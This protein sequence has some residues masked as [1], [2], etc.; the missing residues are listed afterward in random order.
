MGY[1]STFSLATNGGPE[2]IIEQFRKECDRAM[3]ALDNDGYPAD[4]AKWYSSNEDVIAFSAKHPDVLF[5]LESKGEEGEEACIYAKG[6]QHY[7]ESSPAWT[8]PPFDA[9]KLK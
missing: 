2:D 3:V 9:S 8:P 4:Q 5:M 6:G 7:I 1:Y